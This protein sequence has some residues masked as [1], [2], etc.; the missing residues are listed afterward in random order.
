MKT[1][2]HGEEEEEEEEEGNDEFDI[3]GGSVCRKK[4]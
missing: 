1:S 3:L 2:A 4:V